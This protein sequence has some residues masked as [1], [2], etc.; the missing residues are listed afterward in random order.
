MFSVV[1]DDAQGRSSQMFV[2][3][4]L[5]IRV[6]VRSGSDCVIRERLCLLHRNTGF[7]LVRTES[8]VRIRRKGYGAASYEAPQNRLQSNERKTTAFKATRHPMLRGRGE[9]TYVRGRV[10][11]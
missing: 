6:P 9:Q 7:C 2:D 4:E 10:R 8:S 3:L 5:S 11:G 1:K